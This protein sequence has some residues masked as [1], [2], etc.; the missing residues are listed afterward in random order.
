M[1]NN[2]LLTSLSSTLTEL[3]SINNL[4]PIQKGI[5]FASTQQDFIYADVYT[6][7]N[8]LNNSKHPFITLIPS[9]K[10]KNYL[11][12]GDYFL[13]FLQ[14]GSLSMKRIGK[15]I[16]AVAIVVIDEE[17]RESAFIQLLHS[18]ASQYCAMV[19][20][21]FSPTDDSFA[22]L[23]S[24]FIGKFINLHMANVELDSLELI[25]N[26]QLNEDL[27]SK[28][29]E[30]THLNVIAPIILLTKEAIQQE[31]HIAVVRKNLNAQLGLIIRKEESSANTNETSTA[32]KNLIQYWVT[33]SE[34]AMRTKYEELIKPNTG[35]YSI[36]MLQW[37]EE[38]T[39]LERSEMADK[40]EKWLAQVDNNFTLNLERKV[41]EQLSID[42]ANEYQALLTSAD[43][44][45]G[46]INYMLKT[47]EILVDESKI[48]KIDYSRFPEA[49]KTL[50][51]YTGFTKSYSG[52]LIKK[53]A[54]EYFVALREYTGLIMVVA[55][56]L[57]PLNMISSISDNEIL[58]TFSKAI[59]IIT[60]VVT[61]VMIIYGYFDLRK[62][63]PQ[64]RKEDFEREL[65]KAK[66]TL[67][68]EIKRMFVESNK[69]WQSNINLWI[70]ETSGQLQQQL[71]TT[72]RNFIDNQTKKTNEEKLRLQRLNQGLDNN[73]KRITSAERMLEGISRSYKD[74]MTDI[75]KAIR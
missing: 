20:L 24:N 61:I 1:K 71:E 22:V 54:I 29:K 3:G 70:R 48:V 50:N 62:R 49:K 35:S 15:H 11:N 27:K 69:D 7:E 66:E 74:A 41:R 8:I 60:G 52:E 45:V 19:V 65:R 33:D 56:L 9:L 14:N 6:S 43:T 39:E 5:E 44:L 64:R 32:I 12:I 28:I 13:E 46:K 47:K 36:K 4:S 17:W 55:G 42:F 23:K 53:G 2:I 40:S 30:R 72:I 63:I 58:K 67:L 51:S 75:E 57:A 59:R 10:E 37:T 73:A 68:G 16:P 18:N 26:E 34:K 31:Q 25:L 38:L 21:N